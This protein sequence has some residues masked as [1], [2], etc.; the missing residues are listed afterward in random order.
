MR[1]VIINAWPISK[2]PPY[3]FVLRGTWAKVIDAFLDDQ[4]PLGYQFIPEC[5]Q[6]NGEERRT[7]IEKRQ[8]MRSAELVFPSS[9]P[10]P[11]VDS[12]PLQV[13][14]VRKDMT[15]VEC[16]AD[17]HHWQLHQLCRCLDKP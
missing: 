14:I 7:R 11:S 10:K 8:G 2:P 5:Q 9:K 12:E 1:Y 16:S 13:R 4:K 15:F 17:Q 6:Q 3:A